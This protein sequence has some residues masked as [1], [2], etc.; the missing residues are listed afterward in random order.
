M[1]T[2]LRHSVG[3][4]TR[5]SR[6][7]RAPRLAAA[8]LAHPRSPLRVALGAGHEVLA[9]VKADR[10]FVVTLLLV[11]QYMYFARPQIVA[12]E[13][14]IKVVTHPIQ[15]IYCGAAAQP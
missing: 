9:V 10:P 11:L 12:V 2:S 7:K 3:V 1:Y 8:E 14:F 15:Q 5:A 13:V 6:R 4:T